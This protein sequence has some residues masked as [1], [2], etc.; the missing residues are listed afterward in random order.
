VTKE[1]KP[2]L[3]FAEDIMAPRPAKS[4]TKTVKGK[5]KKKGT[6]GKESAE[7]GIKIRK[8]RRESDFQEEEEEY[9]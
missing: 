5:K 3:R 7:D 4:S 2:T 8:G 6:Y 1:E 9:Y